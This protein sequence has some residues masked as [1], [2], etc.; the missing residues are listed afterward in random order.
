M[1]QQAA[2]AAIAAPYRRQPA[3]N[4]GITIP[5]LPSFFMIYGPN[6]LRI[7]PGTA[8]VMGLRMDT[9]ASYGECPND[10]PSNLWIPLIG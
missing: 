1:V 2:D 4:L 5:G 8:V 7:H 6:P 10:P 3:R 9:P